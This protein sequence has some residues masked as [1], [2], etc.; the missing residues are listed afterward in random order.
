MVKFTALFRGRDQGDEGR[1]MSS[2]QVRRVDSDE[3]K[4]FRSSGQHRASKADWKQLSLPPLTAA[5]SH[6]VA[7]ETTRTVP[8]TRGA[9]H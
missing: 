6:M 4:C 3:T 1:L 5:C 8:W 9:W 2:Q 7:A